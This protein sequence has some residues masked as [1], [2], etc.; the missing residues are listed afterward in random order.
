VR[1]KANH[2]AMAKDDALILISG[3]AP[4]DIHWA[5]DKGERK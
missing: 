5:D 4:F 3:D 2:W 1:S